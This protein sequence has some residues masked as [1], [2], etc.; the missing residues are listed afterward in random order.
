[1]KVIVFGATG[2]VG[3]HFVQMAVEASHEV[4]AFVRTP[5]KL[6]TTNGVNILKG[7]LLMK[8]MLRM[9]SQVMM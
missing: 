5:E 4:T 3:Q 1:M 8:M 6:K 7:M 9:Q 2:G